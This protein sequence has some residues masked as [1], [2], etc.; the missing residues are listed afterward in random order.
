LTTF[1]HT[2]Q[3]MFEQ[4]SR[5]AGLFD[6]QLEAAV[7]AHDSSSHANGTSPDIGGGHT[8][9]HEEEALSGRRIKV[10]RRKGTP[11]VGRRGTTIAYQASPP[12]VGN[13]IPLAQ[14][15]SGVANVQDT[16]QGYAVSSV[17]ACVSMCG[18]SNSNLKGIHS[19]AV[20]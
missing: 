7:S 12:E 14:V 15:T 8:R 6:P 16:W 5:L 11:L 2:A 1:V 10:P 13:P 19:F 4:V 20:P 18:V 17:S 3:D 9:K